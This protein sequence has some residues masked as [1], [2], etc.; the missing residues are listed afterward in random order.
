MRQ[1]SEQ[2]RLET[3]Q[4]VTALRAPQ[5]R[6]RWGEMQL[7]RTV[8]AAGMTEHVDFVTQDTVDER[9]RRLRP[10]LVVRLAGGK[11]VVV[12]SKVAFAGYLEAMEARDEAT[13]DA[14]LK[15][16]ARHL[17]THI[18]QLGAKA[19]WEHFSPTPEF[20]VCFV[21]A[22][23]FLDA[24]LQEDPT[25]HGAGL[26]AERRAGHA[27]HAGGAAAHRRLHLAAGGAGRQRRRG[28]PARPRALPAAVDDGRPHR[29]ARAAR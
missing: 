22:D 15:A 23:A 14:R 20:V 12:D 25:L 5:V 9:R 27:V 29:Q 11:N 28:A 26:R 3:A 19:Y 18:D 10:D 24:A 16:H 8:E 21:P 2:L 6:G 13:R 17:R 7:Q 1:T 4:L